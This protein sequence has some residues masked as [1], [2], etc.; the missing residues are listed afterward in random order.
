[1]KKSNLNFDTICLA[2]P[3]L[4]YWLIKTT[5]MPAD[6][7]KKNKYPLISLGKYKPSPDEALTFESNFLKL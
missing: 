3:T 7:L 1:M 5:L 6:Y 2:Y 4:L